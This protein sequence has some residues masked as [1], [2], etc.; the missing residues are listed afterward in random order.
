MN[1]TQ[2]LKAFPGEAVATVPTEGAASAAADGREVELV[3]IP[4]VEVDG[5][6]MAASF[7]FRRGKL[8]VVRL[9]SEFPGEELVSQFAKTYP[10]MIERYGAACDLK[11]NE[12][13]FVAHFRKGPTV[14]TLRL[15]RLVTLK[16]TL[17]TIMFSEWSK[18]KG[19]ECH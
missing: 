7:G 12:N 2:V 9:T 14:I 8:E 5:V 13:E 6:T 3:A 16:K 15:V 4:T 18:S 1:Q 17:M 10:V 19:L 11:T